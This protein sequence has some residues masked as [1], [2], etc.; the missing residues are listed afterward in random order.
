[1][2]GRPWAEPPA[3]LCGRPVGR[4]HR[5]AGT[6]L[7]N[8]RHCAGAVDELAELAW[9]GL[10]CG[11]EGGQ[12]RG[13]ASAVA[14]CQ[15]EAAAAAHHLVRDDEGEKGDGFPR[16]RRHLQQRMALRKGVGRWGLEVRSGDAAKR[17]SERKWGKGEGG[18]RVTHTHTDTQAESGTKAR[19]ALGAGGAEQRRRAAD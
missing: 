6:H 11:E 3:R 5:A 13:V 2:T 1:M 7:L 17:S 16:A 12:P 10:R 9:E 4:G 15:S 18:K 14:V 19:S 8:L